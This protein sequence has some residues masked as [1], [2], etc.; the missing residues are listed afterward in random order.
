MREPG[1]LWAVRRLTL[2]RG[3]KRKWNI[4]R[5]R[6]DLHGLVPVDFKA[7]AQHFVACNNGFK[8]MLQCFPVQFPA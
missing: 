6:D 2:G 5:G 4:Q 1:V 7:R 3:L 8:C